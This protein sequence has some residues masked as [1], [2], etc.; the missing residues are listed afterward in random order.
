MSA[1]TTDRRI[2]ALAIGASAGGIDAL[3]TVLAGLTRPTC[4][5]VIVVLHLPAAHES[6]LAEIFAARLPLQ[7]REALPGSRLE[8]GW[9][10][11]APPD[12]HL[13]VEADRSFSLSC[14]P[15]VHY[16][17]PAIDL[18]FESCAEAYGPGLAAVVLTGANE[19]GAQGLARVRERGGLAVVQD[20]REAQHAAMPQAALDLAGA[21]LV[22]PLAAIQELLPTLICP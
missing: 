14:E 6:R 11:F 4:A 19:D 12:Y 9:L 20:P 3:F 2:E 22:L 7:V 18:L 10:Y 1:A 13:L 8:P 17:R 16:S 5:P 21:D 15:P